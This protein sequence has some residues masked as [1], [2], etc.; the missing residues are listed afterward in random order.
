MTNQVIA[1]VR[2]RAGLLTL[3][4]PKALNALTLDMIRDLTAALLAW[5]DDERICACSMARPMKRPAISSN[6]TCSA[7]YAFTREL[8]T[9]NAP[10]VPEGAFTGT[11]TCES[12]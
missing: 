10:T 9:S 1:E 4:R 8:A 11:K 6:A 7:L 5:R 3:N 12:R 2:G